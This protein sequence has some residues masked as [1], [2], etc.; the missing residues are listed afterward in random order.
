EAR[1]QG[2]L[3]A[4]ARAWFGSWQEVPLFSSA[5]LTEMVR[6]PALIVEPNST[7]VLE[8]GW[9]ARRLAGGELMLDVDA[10]GATPD[11][12][13]PGSVNA[14]SATPGDTTPDDATLP[15]RIEIF[16]N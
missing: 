3:P 1:A 10:G 5:S 4:T 2:E 11:D 16:N 8:P 13:T 12:A 6:G 7:L 15:A 14:G 9:R